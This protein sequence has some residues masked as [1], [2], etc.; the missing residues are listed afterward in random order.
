MG[1]ENPYCIK[2]PQREFAPPPCFKFCF[3]S[4]IEWITIKKSFRLEGISDC[5]QSNL[6]GRSTMKLV[7]FSLVLKSSKNGDCTASW[8]P[9]QL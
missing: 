1:H 8:Q 7:L 9:A 3:C 4:L 2:L 6:K 5:P